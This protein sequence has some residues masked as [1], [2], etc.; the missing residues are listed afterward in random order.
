MSG[1]IGK[2]GTGKRSSHKSNRLL[3]AMC[4]ERRGVV[5]VFLHL[6]VMIFCERVYGF[7][8]VLAGHP[9]P[10]RRKRQ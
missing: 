2:E 3:I 10:E 5:H 9:G 4:G 6:R 7:S 1:D 8:S